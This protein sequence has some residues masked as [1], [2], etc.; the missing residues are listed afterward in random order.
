RLLDLLAFGCAEGAAICLLRLHQGPGAD[1]EG[2]LAGRLLDDSFAVAE[3]GEG[4]AQLVLVDRIVEL[5]GHDRAAGEVDARVEPSWQHKRDDARHQQ[6]G[7]EQVEDPPI[8]NEVEHAGLASRTY[9]G[10][11]P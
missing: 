10:W 8:A 1:D 4:I 11:S 5:D 7:R 6:H 3:L 9:D 2:V